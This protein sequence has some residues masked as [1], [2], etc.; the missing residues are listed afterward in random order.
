[1]E[2]I[3]TLCAFLLLSVAMWGVKVGIAIVFGYR[4][5]AL[6]VRGL[7]A[8]VM[9]ASLVWVLGGLHDGTIMRRTLTLLDSGL[10][11]ALG[12]GI[13]RVTRWI[14]EHTGL[15]PAHVR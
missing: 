13:A 3:G 6:W 9:A 4:P 11:V 15:R 10:I 1:M 14:D 5:T 7:V 12:A 2:P 8:L